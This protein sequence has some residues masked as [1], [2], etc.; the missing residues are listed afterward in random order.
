[1]G[2][3]T[4]KLPNPYIHSECWKKKFEN[5]KNSQDQITDY[6]YI[7][8]QTYDNMYPNIKSDLIKIYNLSKDDTEL[9]NQYGWSLHALLNRFK[10]LGY[11]SYYK[12]YS[13]GY[14]S[15]FILEN[16]KLFL[17]NTSQKPQRKKNYK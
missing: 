6:Y 3:L 16:Y 15:N 11:S 17:S 7:Q 8:A 12:F 1:M 13:I 4:I 9:L 14:T 5:Y 10:F 2:Y